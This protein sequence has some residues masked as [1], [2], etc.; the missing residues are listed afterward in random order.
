MNKHRI[1]VID[2]DDTVREYFNE[3][4]ERRGYTVDVASGGLDAVAKVTRKDYDVVILDIRM[5]DMSGHEVLKRIKKL[6]PDTVVIMASAYQSIPDAVKS[7]RDGAYDYLPKPFKE[8][9]FD[10][11]LDRAVEHSDLLRENKR[12]K[13]R[14]QMKVDLI[15]KSPA[16]E[17]IREIIDSVSETNVTVLVTGQSG[18]GKEVVSRMIHESSTRSQYP[19]IRINCAALPDTLLESELFGYEK[20]AFTGADKAKEGK[21]EAADKGTILLD[22]I[23]ETSP[24]FQAK[25]LRVIQERELSRVGSNKTI[26]IDTRIIATSN[27][28]LP[29][30]VKEGEFREDLYFRINVIPINIPPLSERKEDIPFL[31]NHFLKR[32]S[33]EN[34][35]KIITFSRDAMRLLRQYSYPGNARELQN[36]IERAV[37]LSSSEIIEPRDLA[38]DSSYDRTPSIDEPFMLENMTL[39]DMEKRMILAYLRKTGGNRSQVARILDVSVRTIRNKLIDYR[40]EG[41]IVDGDGVATYADKDK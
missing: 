18:T 36:I 8:R 14:G 9:N 23:S 31:A 40:K 5:P 16:I 19:F 17:R 7:I 28:D 1:L 4:L 26:K 34:G 21:F 20:G 41:I 13:A 30:L 33:L 24:A 39:A 37:V 3:L 27:R 11:L 29:K 2:D 12:L 25:L 32:F 15:G 35:K 10:L 22:E 6:S 38:L